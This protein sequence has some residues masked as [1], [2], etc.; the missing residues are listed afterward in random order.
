MIISCKLFFLV[1]SYGL[2]ALGIA[3]EALSFGQTRREVLGGSAAIFGGVMPS[4]SRIISPNVASADSHTIMNNGA[5]FASYQIFPDE[6]AALYPTLRPIK[7][8]D[9]EQIFSMVNSTNGGAL[10]LG[11]HHNSP[12]DHMLQAGFIRTIHNLRKKKFGAKNSNMSVGLE[13]IQL[14]FQ[15]VLDAYISKKIT[16]D[17]MK[18]LV[19]WEKRWSWSFDN[20]LPIFETCRELNI[21]LIAL[22]VD[23]EDLGLIELG[24]FP[25]LPKEKLQ[26]YISNP[27]GFATYATSPYFKTYVDY[28]IS[29]SY[30]LHQQMGILRTTITGQRLDED[31][32]SLQTKIEQK[33]IILVP[34]LFQKVILVP[35]LFQFCRM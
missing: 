27:A 20:Y 33:W 15:P 32:P 6:S 29:P 17:K 28:V 21:P 1:S 7:Q 23:S 18:E 8:F 22:N 16:A 24:G 5:S 2:V 25:N 4:S 11:E 13:M 9:L 30:D 35:F 26:K 3:S 10:W 34:F 31:M 19:Q 12:R 14:Q